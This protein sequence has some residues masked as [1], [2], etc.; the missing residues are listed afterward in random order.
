[1][2]DLYPDLA[3]QAGNIAIEANINR[4]SVL[5]LR[6]NEVYGAIASIPG[7]N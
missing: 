3:N 7:I 2:P 6:Y 4:L 5:G 1:L